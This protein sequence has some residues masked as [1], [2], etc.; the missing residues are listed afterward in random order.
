MNIKGPVRAPPMR[1]ITISNR[2]RSSPMRI[3][4]PTTNDR[5]KHRLYVKSEKLNKVSLETNSKNN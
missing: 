4:S 1:P 5:T 2:G 3:A